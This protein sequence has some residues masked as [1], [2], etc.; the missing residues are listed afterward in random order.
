MSARELSFWGWGWADKFPDD[1]TRAGLAASVASMLG[2]SG[3]APRPV[4]RLADVVLHPSRL[5]APAALAPFTTD[6]H[7][8][9]IFH[10]YGKGFR[11]LVRGFEKDF[12]PAPDLVCRPRDEADVVAALAWAEKERVAVIP[13]G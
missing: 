1:D 11:D 8:A 12:A 7:A 3:L 9:R 4:P 13:F 5:V 10:T 2:F 6:D